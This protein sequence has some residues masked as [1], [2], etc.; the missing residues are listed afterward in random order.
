MLVYSILFLLLSNAVTL[1]RDKSIL[2]SRVAIIV[3]IYCSSLAVYSLIIQNTFKGIGIFGGLFHTTSITQTFQIFIFLISAVILQLTAFYHRSICYYIIILVNN[4]IF[5]DVYKAFNE[6]KGLF[7]LYNIFKFLTYLVFIGVLSDLFIYLPFDKQIGVLIILLGM[8]IEFYDNKKFFIKTFIIRIGNN[9]RYFFIILILRGL[10][11]YVIINFILFLFS[12]DIFF[13][14]SDLL[15]YL[16][17]SAI[18]KLAFYYWDAL[19]DISPHF[20][21]TVKCDSWNDWDDFVQKNPKVIMPPKFESLSVLAPEVNR[22]KSNLFY[23][24]GR[25]NMTPY[26]WNSFHSKE[27]TVYG[28]ATSTAPHTLVDAWPLPKCKG[29]Y[30][31]LTDRSKMGYGSYYQL[32]TTITSF[33]GKPLYAK[34]TEGEFIL[35]PFTLQSGLKKIK[36]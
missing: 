11:F 32:D 33:A 15:P 5:T 4:S 22:S 1:R 35:T 2:F 6:I 31:I 10:S 29:L 26:H 16:Q 8:V 19:M 27:L 20:Y 7:K 13:V 34:T 21:F 3:L 28:Q 9:K 12:L 36:S 18:K 30:H 17:V 23:K 25:H 14:G 24:S